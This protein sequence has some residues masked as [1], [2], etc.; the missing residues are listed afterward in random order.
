M[1]GQQHQ[2]QL[3]YGASPAVSN[4]QAAD[5]QNDPNSLVIHKALFNTQHYSFF[6]YKMDMPSEFIK[7]DILYSTKEEGEIL[8]EWDSQ[9]ND[10]TMRIFVDISNLF[11]SKHSYAMDLV[12]RLE[13][14]S[15]PNILNILE[16]VGLIDEI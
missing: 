9:A 2:P 6:L 5:L 4:Q 1:L 16:E 12:S 10:L 11:E 15:H 7:P 14:V 13:R 3:R 8:I